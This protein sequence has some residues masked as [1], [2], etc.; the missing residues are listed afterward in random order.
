VWRGVD[1]RRPRWRWRF[2][3]DISQITSRRLGSG[4][5][6]G[7]MAGVCEGFSERK[8]LILTPMTMMSAGVVTLSGPRCGYLPRVRNQGESS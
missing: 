1:D 8:L 5:L 2:G 7:P 3:N 4:T 6:S